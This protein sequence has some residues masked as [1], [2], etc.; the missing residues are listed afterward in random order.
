MTFNSLGLVTC[1]RYSFAPNSL[2]YCG[3][4]KQN[5]MRAYV[6]SGAVDQGLFEILNRF[7]TLYK[8]LQMISTEN[9]IRDPFD[10][11]VV[12]A[13]WLGNGLLQKT[14]YQPLANLLNDELQL[15]KKLTS[16]QLRIT[17][18]KLDG[19]VAH[20]T[21]HVLNIFRR[22]G[23]HAIP[24][25]LETMDQCR[26]SWGKVVSIYNL[27]FTINNAKNCMIR[28]HVKSTPLIYEKEKLT[29]GKPKIKEVISIG[30]VP[31]VGEWVS[32]HWG[33][34]CDILTYRQVANLKFYTELAI[35]LANRYNAP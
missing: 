11:R 5:N 4:E 22:T 10:P 6:S 35:K 8:Y 15:K 17:L 14:K 29:L 32:V 23:H 20:H 9:D 25:T 24:H 2:H 33:Y 34:V 18:S 1:A 7:E 13:Y 3:P 26:V 16:K 27:Q 31:K 21:F 30:L 19:G 12:E 28:L